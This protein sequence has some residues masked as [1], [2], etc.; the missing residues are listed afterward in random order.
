MRNT[1]SQE[2][3]Q[4]KLNFLVCALNTTNTQVNWCVW[5]YSRSYSVWILGSRGD[6]LL[7]CF[8]DAIQFQ[9]FRRSHPSWGRSLFWE[10]YCLDDTQRDSGRAQWNETFVLVFLLI[11]LL[12]SFFHDITASPAV[13][14]LKS[15]RPVNCQ[16]LPKGIGR[17]WPDHAARVWTSF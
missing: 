11:L 15:S 3:Q 8:L 17:M 16:L 2:E 1:T 9:S 6:L 10:S 7:E 12:Q 4:T 13:M 14:R 5:T